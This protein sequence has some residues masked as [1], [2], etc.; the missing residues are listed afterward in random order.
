MKGRVKGHVKGH[1]KG[2]G[3]SLERRVRA[4]WLRAGMPGALS[5]RTTTPA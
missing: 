5:G 4:A 1:V 3:G 2:K